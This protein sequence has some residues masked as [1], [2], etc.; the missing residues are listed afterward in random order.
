M[1]AHVIKRTK[2][3]TFGILLVVALSACQS[4]SIQDNLSIDYQTYK[5][6][7]KHFFNPH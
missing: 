6:S 4:L 1:L 2:Q 3:I 7:I 5:D